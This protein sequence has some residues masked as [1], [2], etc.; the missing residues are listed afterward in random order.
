MA[1]VK[2]NA[3]GHGLRE[4]VHALGSRNADWFGVDSLE[5]AVAVRSAGGRQPILIM[6]YVPPA[7]LASVVRNGFSMIIYDM[8]RLKMLERLATTRRPAKVH[9]KLETGTSRQG[10]TPLELPALAKTLRRLRNV[11][12]EGVSTH[13]A[14]VEDTSDQSYAREQLRRFHEGLTLLEKAGLRPTLR[15]TAASA[16]TLLHPE[17][18][19]DLVRT[20]VVLYGLW[21][22]AE[23]EAAAA[24]AGLKIDLHP[25][26]TWKTVIAQVK[27]LPSGTPVSYG[28]T[29]RLKRPSR[30]AVLPVGYYD[31]L[32]RGLSS[33]GRM[34]VRGRR[35]KVLG[36]VCMNMCVVDVTDVP[37]AAAGDEAVIIGRQNRGA[38]AAEE[39]A[40]AAGTI[41]YEIVARLNPLLPR[42]LA[43]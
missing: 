13:F 41:N 27:S 24:D 36:R 14:N 37:G 20:G 26:L 4:V 5:E 21:P 28:L 8:A 2:A 42:R 35:V 12:L 43:D 9:L 34:L 39:V 10:A 33:V 18:K 6:G 19:F 31:G 17:A 11:E 30:V 1:V 23:T 3:Y 40:E 25:V 32:D 15:H 7:G 29:E 16:G 22:S 38:I